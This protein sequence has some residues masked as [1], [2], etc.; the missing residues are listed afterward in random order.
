MAID[1]TGTV[2][3]I[4]GSSPT[5]YRGRI[6]LGDGSRP[7]VPVPDPLCFD[8][9]K[10]G[11]YVRRIQDLE[12]ERGL[13]LAKKR[14]A[15]PAGE[16]VDAWFGRYFAWRKTRGFVVTRDVETRLRR[17]VVDRLA[18]K[19]MASV[20][21]DDIEGIVGVLDAEIALRTRYYEELGEEDD[22]EGGRKPGLSWKTA[23]NA[24]SDITCAFDEACNSK[25]RSLR[26]LDRDPTDRVRGPERG[27][28]REKPFLFP[29][30][31]AALLACRDVPL[32]WRI[33]YA[34]AAYAGARANELAALVAAD[35]DLEHGRL[36]ITKQV[37]RNTG[38]L[39]PT[40]TKRTRTVD[41]E[42]TLLALVRVLVER[43]GEG[44]LLRMPPDE[45]RADLLRRHLRVAGCARE[46][47]FADDAQRAPMRFHGLRDTCLTFMAIRGD[48]PLRIQWRAGHTSFAMTE[49]YISQARRF[50][51]GF[52]TPFAPLPQALFE[53]STNRST[54]LPVSRASTG[55]CSATPTGI[56]PAERRKDAE[57]AGDSRNERVEGSAPKSANLRGT[58][59]VDRALRLVHSRRR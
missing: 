2:E 31:L 54:G 13:L 35:V 18:G 11:A 37:D 53:R 59:H 20:T 44:R 55:N 6:R 41:I 19:P 36:S 4:P 22:D 30:E 33:M 52:G 56:E 29:S 48:E 45:D 42:P 16:T 23:L 25:E 1:R 39:R 28:E 32:H 46:A 3:E 9:E 58:V 57:S 49:K 26:T 14:N 40:K 5:R 50:E 8:R 10:A 43:A 17:F 27:I 24:W 7:R 21:R 47:L 38:K 34:V 12:N 15:A 51:A